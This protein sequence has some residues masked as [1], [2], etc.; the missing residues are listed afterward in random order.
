MKEQEPPEEP[1]KDLL[2]EFFF[3][4]FGVRLGWAE[5]LA[6]MPND[7]GAHW[8][9]IFKEINRKYGSDEEDN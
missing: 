8:R 5:Q 4:L 6:K 2:D 9:A 7:L 1:D 3:D